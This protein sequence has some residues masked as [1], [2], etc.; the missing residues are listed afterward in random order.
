MDDEVLSQ[1]V[2]RNLVSSAN[3]AVADLNAS[4]GLL[5][6]KLVL[7]VEDDACDPKQARSVARLRPASVESSVT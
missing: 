4:G 6:K 2:A 1:L 7:D 3:H 5:G